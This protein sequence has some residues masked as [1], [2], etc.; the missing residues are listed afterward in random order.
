M[1][2]GVRRGMGRRGR[3]TAAI[4]ATVA[5]VT[6][7]AAAVA[8]QGSA[9][10]P[11]PSIEPDR[12]V[13]STLQ[14]LSR[15]DPISGRMVAFA[16]LGL[17]ALPNVA[18]APKATGLLAFV[19]SLSG[20]HHL[21]VWRS[22]DGARVTEL[23]PDSE[24]A[25]YVTPA[26]SWAWDFASYTAYHL[27]S[28]DG[29]G[30][31][32]PDASPSPIDPL[33]L[34]QRALRAIT[35][36]TAVTVGPDVQVAGRSTYALTL[37]PRTDRT[38]VGRIEIDVDGEH[39]LPLR[40][41]V[42]ARGHTRPSLSAAFT[43]VGFS[44]IDPGVYRFSPPPGA[45]VRDL[46]RPGGPAMS[47]PHGPNAPEPSDVDEYGP[48]A[49]AFG[50]GWATVIALLTPPG[51][52][53]GREAGLDIETFLP[54]SAPLLSIRLVDRGDHAWLLYGAVPQADLV[55]LEDRLP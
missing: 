22:P 25:L 31:P 5:V 10:A 37:E 43:S 7:A 46:T 8:G 34:A 28:S 45:T 51:R 4:V 55:A 2:V 47:S 16:D 54:L 38:L 44:P 6:G 32:A 26:A 12:L 42:T 18:G 29:G 49:R 53:L 35:P 41:A 9:P 36:T 13:A 14:A 48:A 3:L 50:S 33:A 39:W 24:R 40:V 23:L 30:P 21:K 27:P 1:K 19:T 15:R 52:Q 17:P 11:L 20:T